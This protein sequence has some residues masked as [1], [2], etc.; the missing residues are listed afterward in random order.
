MWSVGADRIPWG[1]NDEL[2]QVGNWATTS[3]GALSAEYH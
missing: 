3:S 2:Q 1:S